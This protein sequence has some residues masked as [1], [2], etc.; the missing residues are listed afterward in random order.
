MNINQIAGALG[1]EI[2]VIDLAGGMSAQPAVE[3][4]QRFLNAWR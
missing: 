3:I 1:A 2:S 4:R